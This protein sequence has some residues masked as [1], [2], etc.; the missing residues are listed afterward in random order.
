[1]HAGNGREG[2]E[3]DFGARKEING[4]EAR[5]GI[6]GEDQEAKASMFQG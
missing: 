1:M 6:G 5:Y 2:G 4:R 3:R